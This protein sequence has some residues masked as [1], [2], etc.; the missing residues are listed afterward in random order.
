[1]ALSRQSG[2]TLSGSVA[3][4]GKMAHSRKQLNLIL[5]SNPAPNDNLTWIRTINDIVSPKSAFSK[6]EFGGTPDWTYADAQKAL[7]TGKVAV[8]SSHTIKN[9]TF[10]TPS[11]MEAEAYGG[12]KVFKKIVSISDVAWIDDVQGQYAKVK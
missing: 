10:V 9:G 1:M 2:V 12:G 11:K 4:T 6:D 7:K 5:A 8:Y 3:T